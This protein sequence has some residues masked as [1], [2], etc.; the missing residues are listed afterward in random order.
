METP[1]P[2]VSRCRPLTDTLELTSR[3]MACPLPVDA[4][5]PLDGFEWDP[6][7]GRFVDHAAG[8]VFD[9]AS[10]VFTQTCT[11]DEYI[12]DKEARLFRPF[13]PQPA[14]SGVGWLGVGVP[15]LKLDAARLKHELSSTAE[16]TARQLSSTAES[17]GD[18]VGQLS[19]R[20]SL[21]AESLT[22]RASLTP[23]KAAAMPEE[24]AAAVAAA[25]HPTLASGD[26]SGSGHDED[27]GSSG[28]GG[29]GGGSGGGGGG[30]VFGRYL[31]RVRVRVRVG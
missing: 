3:A 21:T 9:P 20:I 18:F 13:H 29:G 31:V 5:I 10:S 19:R 11:Q 6:A 4:A 25:P 26:A 12:F 27:D 7:S 8:Y 23:G 24:A 2:Q 28:G 16:N 30:G 15:P 14:E 17:L 22:P 1:A